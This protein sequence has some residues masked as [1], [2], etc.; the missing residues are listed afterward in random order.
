MGIRRI[1]GI[2]RNG[3][4]TTVLPLINPKN[5]GFVVARMYV[6]MIQFVYKAEALIKAEALMEDR[7]MDVID[8]EVVIQR[9]AKLLLDIVREI[10]PRNF[11]G[12]YFDGIPPLAKVVEQRARRY[13]MQLVKE[14]F[15]KAKNTVGTAFLRGVVEAVMAGLAEN[16]SILPPEVEVSTPSDRGEG[17]H[18]LANRIRD[19]DASQPG[20]KVIVS[21]DG[22]VMIMAL[23]NSWKNCYVYVDHTQPK[24]VH[25]LVSI[26]GI[27]ER[28]RYRLGDTP[29]AV[30]DFCLM[31]ILTGGNDF[32]PGILSAR[33]RREI[34]TQL[35]DMY[36][37][38]LRG[39][40]LMTNQGKEIVWT[41]VR[42]LVNELAMNEE[43]NLRSVAEEAKKKRNGRLPVLFTQ[44]MDPKTGEIKLPFFKKAWDEDL[45]EPKI[46]KPA[47]PESIVIP[48]P[49]QREID[50]DHAFSA[51]Q[52]LQG[53]SWTLGYMRT[54]DGPDWYYNSA[55]PPLFGDIAKVMATAGVDPVRVLRTLPSWEP[56]TLAVYLLT[57]LPRSTAEDLFGDTFVN[58]FALGAGITDL[59]PKKFSHFS[60]AEWDDTMKGRAI[61]PPLGLDRI[62][63]VVA[64]RLDS[65]VIERNFNALEPRV[66]FSRTR[67]T[68]V[69]IGSKALTPEVI[70]ARKSKCGVE[71]EIL[72]PVI[73]V[74]AS[75]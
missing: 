73:P 36:S 9:T 66:R 28:I 13:E 21:D 57:V 67:G 12:I 46:D 71:Y 8:D 18:K 32:M 43:R 6:D 51:I 48:R 5:R 40:P 24:V 1:L 39:Q 22:D 7:K 20:V 65:V 56:Q 34:I 59:F 62:A 29:T 44:S 75:G 61:L 72:D 68:W 49:I 15:N 69:P 58:A 23:L 25:G 55:Y 42:A 64:E 14:K 26:G 27:V 31:V 4:G 70:E 38:V 50:S 33:D 41:S 11:L 74:L 45:Y 47:L 30:F 60:P 52:Y 37:P 35:M 3:L 54:G 19:K 16:I 53:L 17:E 63:K 10:A 2:L